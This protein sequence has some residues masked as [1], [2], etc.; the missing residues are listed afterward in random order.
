MGIGVGG[1][2][3]VCWQRWADKGVLRTRLRRWRRADGRPV[4]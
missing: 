1:E 3:I 4:T 2:D